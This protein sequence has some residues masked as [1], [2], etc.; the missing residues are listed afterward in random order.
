MST[1]IFY[2]IKE[3]H[4]SQKQAAAVMITVTY[5][6]SRRAPFKRPRCALAGQILHSVAAP[7]VLTTNPIKFTV[8]P[9][10]HLATTHPFTSA[11]AHKNLP[12]F[13][14]LALYSHCRS[15]HITRRSIAIAIQ[16]QQPIIQQRSRNSVYLTDGRNST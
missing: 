6:C 13:Y 16:C 14:L 10:P 2:A 11:P 8:P 9:L 3:I 15:V 7:S 1:Y 4:T 12:Q 5:V